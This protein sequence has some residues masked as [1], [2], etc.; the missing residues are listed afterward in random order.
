M[1]IKIKKAAMFG[2]DARIALAI[3]GA[4]SVISGAAL[5]SAIQDSKATSSYTTVKEIIKAYESLYIDTGALS[6][7][8]A[9]KDCYDAEDIIVSNAKAGWSGPYMSI[10]VDSTT[11]ASH[12]LMNGINLDND[13]DLILARNLKNSNWGTSGDWALNVSCK[14]S[15][16]NCSLWVQ[17][18]A[19][20]ISNKLGSYLDDKFDDGVAD[21]GN[22]RYGL[23]SASSKMYIY[24]K[25]FVI[26]SQ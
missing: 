26:N 16:D 18:G 9:N 8:S 21:Y 13:F 2:L 25:G 5:Y 7:M 22:I 20:D 17:L 15:T 23:N 10:G 14:T 1:F 24:I 4:L 19:K 6:V 12:S 3:F 11:I